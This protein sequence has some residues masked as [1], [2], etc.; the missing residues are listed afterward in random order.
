MTLSVLRAAAEEP[1]RPALVVHRG[2][3]ASAG[4][5][6]SAGGEASAV[7]TF[8]A[9][10]D[11]TRAAMRWLLK[12]G[13]RPGVAGQ[14]VALSADLEVA[15]LVLLYALFELG[16]PVVLLHPRLTAAERAALLAECVP[17][18][19][20]DDRGDDAERRWRFDELLRN[21][22]RWPGQ[23]AAVSWARAGSAGGQL[24][25]NGV[26]TMLRGPV[27]SAA[28]ILALR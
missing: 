25:T 5:A 23:L 28:K 19:V 22:G 13:V 7:V 2:A 18:L 17:T 15:D 16:V 9:L 20:I 8:A 11:A 27:L 21:S 24:R 1:Q 14:R 12:R 10:A 3:E 4:G 26:G 6:A